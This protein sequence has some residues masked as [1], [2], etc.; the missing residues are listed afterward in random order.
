MLLKKG[1]AISI[2]LFV[3]IIFQ[4]GNDQGKEQLNPNAN[5]DIEMMEHDDETENVEGNEKV[6]F[7]F[8]YILVNVNYT[9]TCLC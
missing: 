4:I 2:F 9:Y 5:K 6:K 7:I 1:Y 8:I 3:S